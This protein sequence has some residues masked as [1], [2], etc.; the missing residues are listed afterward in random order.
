MAGWHFR[1]ERVQNAH[2]EAARYFS[3]RHFWIGMPAVLLS[4]VVGTT[5]FAS[6]SEQPEKVYQISVGLISIAAACLTAM[7]TF[8][9]YSEESEKHRLAGA[10]FSNLKHEIEMTSTFL[11]EKDS[12]L[13]EHLAKIEEKWSSYREENP[14]IPD[15]IWKNYNESKLEYHQWSS[16]ILKGSHNKALKNDADKAGAS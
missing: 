4:T 15:R 2:Y 14:S 10:R 13:K 8:L 5:V 6:I 12:E 9:K 7:Q 3:K 16:E 11:L 1:V